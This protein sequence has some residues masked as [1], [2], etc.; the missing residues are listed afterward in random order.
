MQPLGELSVSS[1]ALAPSAGGMVK[2]ESK[3]QSWMESEGK[4]GQRLAP[5]CPLTG[6][7]LLVLQFQN[8]S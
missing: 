6:T 8:A 4:A 3:G 7:I 2:A 5:Y 1:T